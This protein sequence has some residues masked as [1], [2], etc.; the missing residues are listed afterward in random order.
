MVMATKTH[1]SH[2]ESN[3]TGYSVEESTQWKGSLRLVIHSEK[4]QKDLDS[5]DASKRRDIFTKIKAVFEKDGSDPEVYDVD[6]RNDRVVIELVFKS[7][8]CC[9]TFLKN[10][11]TQCTHKRVLQHALY[12]DIHEC[13]IFVG[14]KYIKPADYEKNI[15]SAVCLVNQNPLP[16]KNSEMIDDVTGK[17]DNLSITD[18]AESCEQ[19]CESTSTQ[20]QEIDYNNLQRP[21]T[22]NQQLEFQRILGGDKWHDVAKRLNALG[23]KFLTDA[24]IDTIDVDCRDTPEK[25]YK[26]LRKY[27]D[28]EGKDATLGRLVKAMVLC[29]FKTQAEE[30]IA[31][32]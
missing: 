12:N 26:M 2:Y 7:E 32:E 31:V 10:H 9:F 30:L 19:S 20:S 27:I 11:F 4:T 24:D 18:A 25:T 15:S 3:E 29:G 16:N 14:D 1:K 21:I 5:G 8:D 13:Q 22:R 6:I 23:C 17:M 28:S